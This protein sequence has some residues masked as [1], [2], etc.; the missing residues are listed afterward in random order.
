MSK[1]N[2]GDRIEIVYLPERN[3]IGK[4]GKII[5]IGH[6]MKS[7]TQ[8]ID[9]KYGNPDKEYRFSIQLDDGT[10]LNDLREIQLRQL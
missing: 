6:S 7:S 10:V 1:I 5:F 3:H 8:P 4:Q 9:D 2:M